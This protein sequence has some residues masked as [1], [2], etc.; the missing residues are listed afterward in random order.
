M[1]LKLEDGLMSGSLLVTKVEFRLCFVEEII[2][3]PYFILCFG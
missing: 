2:L 3:S 1:F